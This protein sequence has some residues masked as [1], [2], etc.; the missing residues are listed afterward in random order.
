MS[1]ERV[2]EPADSIAAALVARDAERYRSLVES[3][4]ADDVAAS[5]AKCST[6]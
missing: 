2:S 1:E 3:M 5:A 4:S 6:P